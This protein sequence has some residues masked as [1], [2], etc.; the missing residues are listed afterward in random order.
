MFIVDVKLRHSISDLIAFHNNN[1]QVDVLVL[2][3]GKAF[4]TVSHAKLI[5]KLNTFGINSYLANRIQDWLLGRS[6]RVIV[7]SHFSQPTNVTSGVPQ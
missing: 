1:T 7:N 5:Y 4:D 6:F 2:D 3:F